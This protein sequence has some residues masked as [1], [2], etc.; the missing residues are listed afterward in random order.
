MLNRT[1]RTLSASQN[2]LNLGTRSLAFVAQANFNIGTS[3]LH[4]RHD[5]PVVMRAGTVGDPIDARG[6]AIAIAI[7]R[8]T[9]AIKLP[10]LPGSTSVSP[11]LHASCA[12]PVH[13]RVALAACLAALEEPAVRPGCG[14]RPVRPTG[15]RQQQLQQQRDNRRALTG[16]WQPSTPGLVAASV[17]AAGG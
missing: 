13:P 3:T 12:V 2:R 4:V 14:R 6:I 16:T 7:P 11:W 17:A 9:K 10:T 8:R 15:Q 1:N 5:Y